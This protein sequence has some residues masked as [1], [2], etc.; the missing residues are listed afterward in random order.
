MPQ[1]RVPKPSAFDGKCLRKHLPT[2]TFFI[3]FNDFQRLKNAEKRSYRR[4][5]AMNVAIAFHSDAFRDYARV[6]PAGGISVMHL[7]HSNCQL[8]DAKPYALL[9]VHCIRRH[10]RDFIPCITCRRVHCVSWKCSIRCIIVDVEYIK[11]VP[12]DR[13][14]RQIT[15]RFT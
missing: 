12:C 8:V 5:Y 10:R 14:Q 6:P 11:H 1:F 4:T 3:Y 13:P 15:V 9:G 7:A 2:T